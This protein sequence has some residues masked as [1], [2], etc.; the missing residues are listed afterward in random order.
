MSFDPKDYIP[1]QNI[2]EKERPILFDLVRVGELWNKT[3]PDEMYDT[4]MRNTD[5][6]DLMIVNFL[7]SFRKERNMTPLMF[8]CLCL[9]F[10][11]INFETT[12]TIELIYEDIQTSTLADAEINWG[13][14]LWT[15]MGLRIFIKKFWRSDVY[16][17]RTDLLE[18]LNYFIDAAKLM[19]KRK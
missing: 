4:I 14:L 5:E 18:F 16:G 12:E 2:T 3:H 1:V 19:W 15:C 17:G 11:M 8:Q 9:I 7:L 10:A 6:L 13:V